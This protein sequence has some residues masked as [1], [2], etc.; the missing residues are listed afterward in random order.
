MADDA[1][2]GQ[3]SH[4]VAQDVPAD[5][6]GDVLAELRTI[7]LDAG[8]VLGAVHAHVGD[9]LATKAVHTDLRF[10]VGEAA[11]TWKGNEQH[12]VTRLEAD[13]ADLAR[14]LLL[15]GWQDS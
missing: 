14:Y 10:D 4:G 1:A 13:A 9:A 5:C 8:P 11:S 15:N 7:A 6:L 3:G 12:P 2:V